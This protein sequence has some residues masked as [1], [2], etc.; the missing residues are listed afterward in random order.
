MDQ[1]LS[2]LKTAFPTATTI[3]VGGEAGLHDVLG[4][5]VFLHNVAGLERLLLAASPSRLAIHGHVVGQESF[6]EIRGPGGIRYT[7]VVERELF[8]DLGNLSDFLLANEVFD[9]QVTLPVHKAAT[10]SWNSGPFLLR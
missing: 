2:I 5:A 4:S 1:V 9:T 8:E 6:W 3:V 7:W 10:C